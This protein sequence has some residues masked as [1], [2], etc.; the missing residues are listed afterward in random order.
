MQEENFTIRNDFAVI[1]MT[2]GVPRGIKA[3]DLSFL[4]NQSLPSIPASARTGENTGNPLSIV[5]PRFR[6]CVVMSFWGVSRRIYCFEH[7]V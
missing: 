6:D 2:L 5:D 7:A 4:L 3:A 1:L